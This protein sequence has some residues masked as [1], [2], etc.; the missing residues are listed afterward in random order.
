LKQAGSYL[1]LVG[2]GV[3]RSHALF[4]Y[5][6]A[7]RGVY[8]IDLSTT[9]GTQVNGTRITK[10]QLATGDTIK[11]GVNQFTVELP[12]HPKVRSRSSGEFSTVPPDGTA[13]I[14]GNGVTEPGWTGRSYEASFCKTCK[15]S[16]ICSKIRDQD[17]Q[18]DQPD[19]FECRT[20]GRA[21]AAEAASITDPKK[22]AKL[23]RCI[24]GFLSRRNQ[25][26]LRPA[27]DAMRVGDR[28]LML[29]ELEA[30]L[31]HGRRPP[32]WVP[33]SEDEKDVE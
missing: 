8:L 9:H 28:A 33:L 4:E 26:E 2:D 22:R 7:T 25:G 30:I 5:N 21:L 24:I 12:D 10:Y 14:V 31:L 6:E 3:S 18:C 11:I 23:A 1:Q 17:N 13:P 27:F 29:E 32:N 19:G 16:M 15:R 20:L